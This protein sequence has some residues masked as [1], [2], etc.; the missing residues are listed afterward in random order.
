MG[1]ATYGTAVSVVWGWLGEDKDRLTA[2]GASSSADLVVELVELAPIPT[3][4]QASRIELCAHEMEAERKSSCAC[5]SMT[6]VVR[7]PWLP[8]PKRWPKT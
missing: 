6:I 1:Y 7:P 4:L 3:P 8:R 2:F 5:M